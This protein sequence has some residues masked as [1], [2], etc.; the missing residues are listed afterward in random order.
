MMSNADKGLTNH[1]G[2]NSK[3]DFPRLV[4]EKPICTS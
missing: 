4:G 2:S 1:H 3:E